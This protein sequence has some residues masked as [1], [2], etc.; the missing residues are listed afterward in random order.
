M[1]LHGLAA[2]PCSLWTTLLPSLAALCTSFFRT[3]TDAAL[4]NSA[5]VPITSLMW[6]PEPAASRRISSAQTRS[7][8]GI[9]ETAPPLQT[10]G[11]APN[12]IM[13]P[14]LM[15]SA[16]RAPCGMTICPPHSFVRGSRISNAAPLNSVMNCEAP[17]ITFPSALGPSMTCDLSSMFAFTVLPAISARTNDGNIVTPSDGCAPPIPATLAALPSSIWRPRSLTVAAGATVQLA[18]VSKKI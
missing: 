15:D 9:T 5:T 17:A 11:S 13:P 2:C 4:T 18:P 8:D 16:S 7:T 6:R 12:T 1:Q 3:G 10:D 14:A